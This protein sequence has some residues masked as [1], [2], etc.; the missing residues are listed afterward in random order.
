MAESFLEMSPQLPQV[1]YQ[2][3]VF[4][5]FT[6]SPLVA[7]PEQLVQNMKELPTDNW[8]PMERGFAGHEA[9]EYVAGFLLECSYKDCSHM[10]L[11]QRAFNYSQSF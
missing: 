11:F 1:L 8:I 4:V 3:L 2:S 5:G 7:L 10:L 6:D 9:P